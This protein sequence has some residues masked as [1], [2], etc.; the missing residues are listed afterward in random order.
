MYMTC[1]VET[2]SMPCDEDAVVVYCG[3]SLC[4]FHWKEKVGEL[5]LKV[6]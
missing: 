6:V 5:K 2:E 4:F 3:N 1:I